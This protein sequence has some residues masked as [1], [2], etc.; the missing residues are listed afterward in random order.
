M[1]DYFDYGAAEQAEQ[2]AEADLDRFTGLGAGDQLANERADKRAQNQAKGRNS[3]RSND[4]PDGT[5]DNRG[6]GASEFFDAPRPDHV[7]RYE[8][9][10][11]YKGLDNP[12]PDSKRSERKEP[13]VY[14]KAR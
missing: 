6:T 4:D 1:Q 13:A 12:E 11:Y 3:E 2:G 8:Q 7:V 10:N 5:P 9:H 14:K